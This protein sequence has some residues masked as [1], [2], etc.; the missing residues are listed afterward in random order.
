MNVPPFSLLSLCRKR[1]F[2]FDCV[3]EKGYTQ[4]NCSLTTLGE[5]NQIEQFKTERVLKTFKNSKENIN[6]LFCAKQN[7]DSFLTL[8]FQY[9]QS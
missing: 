7:S 9:I 6:F 4:R 3:S 1:S 8:P 2:K 5:R